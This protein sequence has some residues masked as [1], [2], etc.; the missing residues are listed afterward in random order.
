M[1]I[2]RRARIEDA[3]GI[4]EAH[5]RSIREICSMDHSR[6]EVAAWGNRPYREDHRMSAIRDHLVWVVAEGD[7]IY[8]FGHLIIHEREGEKQGHVL[9]LYLTPEVMAQGFGKQ[10]FESMLTEA[11][12]AK[13][14]K[15]TLE[16]TLTAHEFYKKM[17]FKDSGNEMKI[18]I[19]GVGIRC[20]PMAM[21][22]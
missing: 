16:S 22:I 17:G 12:A 3:P 4:H 6:E 21:T 19:A 10:I 7:R 8:G 1:A 15:L 20:I 18:E 5:M 13:V 9:G 14:K 2:V 11:R